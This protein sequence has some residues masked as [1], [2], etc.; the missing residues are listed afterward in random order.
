MCVLR[1]IG[2]GCLGMLLILAVL[3]CFFLGGLAGGYWYFSHSQESRATIDI[4]VDGRTATINL[5][6]DAML[7][8]EQ[9]DWMLQQGDLQGY[10]TFSGPFDFNF[11]GLRIAVTLPLKQLL[12][13]AGGGS[14]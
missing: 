3:V 5:F 11:L 8:Q 4:P 10:I 1:T 12:G 13:G 6:T 7:S 9:I 14:R 2:F